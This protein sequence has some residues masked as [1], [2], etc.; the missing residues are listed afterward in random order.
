M[1]TA[2]I[3]RIVGAT[4]QHAKNGLCERCASRREYGEWEGYCEVRR[5]VLSYRPAVARRAERCKDFT[6]AQE[7]ATQ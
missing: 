2:N 6:E 5:K 1:S 4:F 3:H 7:E